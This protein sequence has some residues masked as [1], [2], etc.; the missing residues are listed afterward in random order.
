[1]AAQ[2]PLSCLSACTH[3]VVP[4]CVRGGICQFGLQGRTAVQRQNREVLPIRLL[5]EG[6][7]AAWRDPRLALG[8]LGGFAARGDAVVLTTFL[9]LWVQVRTRTLYTRT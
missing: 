1:V 4:V 7:V 3:A 8:Y 9:S 5:S 2:T 6:V